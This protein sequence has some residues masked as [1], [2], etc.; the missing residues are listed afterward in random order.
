MGVS[1]YTIM[2]CVLAGNSLQFGDAH[3][4]TCWSVAVVRGQGAGHAV[5]SPAIPNPH[6]CC[7]HLSH[8]TPATV[9]SAC[10]ACCGP[11]A[12]MCAPAACCANL[13]LL[14]SHLPS[15]NSAQTLSMAC[16]TSGS[17]FW[18]HGFTRAAG[19]PSH[20]V[21]RTTLCTWT[22]GD[23]RIRTCE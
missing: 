19:V 13:A 6:L 15:Q 9:N 16:G 21:N 17:G 11:V 20:G 14:K 12:C 1:R 2:L 10:C 4:A 23:E 22:T 7:T 18:L 5:D 8:A 3:R